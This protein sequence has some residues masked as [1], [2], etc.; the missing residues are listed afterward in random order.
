MSFKIILY[1]FPSSHDILST[2]GSDYTGLAQTLTFDRD[3][4]SITIPVSILN[5]DIQESVE[6]FTALLTTNED[7]TVV[8]F[9][10]PSTTVQIGDDEG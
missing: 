4:T 3:T 9:T 7:P 6:D 2:D 10:T 5:D 8:M 1:I